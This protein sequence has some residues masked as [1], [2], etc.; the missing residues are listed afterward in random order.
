MQFTPQQLAGAGRYGP[1]TRI[2]N[3]QEDVELDETKFMDYAAN[4]AKGKL[5]SNH[6]QN[7]MNKCNAK[8]PHSYSTDGLLRFG[9][10]VV[11]QHV[12]SGGSLA[13]DLWEET[14][15]GTREYSVTV[16]KRTAAVAR[17]TF[18]IERIS[19]DM[20]KD[21]SSE[22]YDKDEIVHYGEPFHLKC[23]DSLLVDTRATH[24]MLKAPLYLSSVMKSDRKSSPV[25]NSQ[26]VYMG[27]KQDSS[28]VWKVQRCVNGS[29]GA[30]QR[31]LAEGSAVQVSQKI[32]LQHR[33]TNQNLC[34][35]PKVF[36]VSDFGDELEVCCNLQQHTGKSHQLV[37]EFS[38][39]STGDTAARSEKATSQWMF[40]TANDPADAVETRN[41][42]EPLSPQALLECVR[43]VVNKRGDYGIRGLARSF[44]I[45]D[46]GNDKMLDRDDF[47]WGLYDYGVHLDDDSFAILLDAFD[48]NKDGY[49]SFDEFL[50]TI[51]GP[52]SDGRKKWVKKAYDILDT[53][54]DQSVT[55]GE[56]AAKYDCSQHP[57]VISGEKSE[58][59]VITEF[60]EQWDTQEADGVITLQEFEEY[61]ADVSASIDSDDYFELM[62]RN[63]W[64]ISGGEGQMANTTCRRVLVTYTDGSQKVC[65]I[66]NDLGI[67]PTDTDKMKDRL[68]AQGEEN[69]KSISLAD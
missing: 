36:D 41:L 39:L 51:R 52:M 58:D 61:Y 15:F 48:K 26:L 14:Q 65:E 9:D 43:N 13:N 69:I 49:I 38:G 68:Q 12:T 17:N 4:K 62:M 54:G 63:A 44:Q 46:D 18:T 29:D 22:D 24:S 25:S 66:Q 28:S 34:A 23:N 16:A 50:V 33:S 3:W 67:G 30:T 19:S 7:K 64:H 53:N 37:S 42:P 8:V 11:L 20:L 40:I 60:M 59:E 10:T 35:D 5:A 55:K 47:K 2:G 27:Y 6:R 31:L 56:I 57:Q 32:V 21:V 45:M 1:K